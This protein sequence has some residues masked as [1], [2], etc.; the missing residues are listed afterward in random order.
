MDI[1]EIYFTELPEIEE[2]N[3]SRDAYERQS[4]EKS[5]INKTDIHSGTE[6]NFNFFKGKD[7]D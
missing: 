7:S 3:D 5:G 6:A 4:E 2:V 1:S